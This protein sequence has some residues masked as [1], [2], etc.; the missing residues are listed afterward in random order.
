VELN[1]G[2]KKDNGQPADPPKVQDDKLTK[3]YDSQ[4]IQLN[5]QIA[6]FGQVSK[7]AEMRW[8][9]EQGALS[10]LL[11]QQKQYL[12]Q[13]TEELDDKVKQKNR[14]D[15]VAALQDEAATYGLASEQVALYRLQKLGLNQA[16]RQAAEAAIEQIQWKRDA[17]EA[18]KDLADETAR[19]ILQRNKNKQ[20][21]E[22]YIASLK[23]E[24]KM[25]SMTSKE[26]A[27][28]KNVASLSADATDD[29]KAAVAALTA[30][31]EDQRKALKDTQ[32]AAKEQSKKMSEF[33]V[34]ASHNMQS[35]F[36]DFFS[37]VRT[38]NKNMLGDFVDTLLR[39]GDE[40]AASEFM[41]LL[42]G[43]FGKT[44]QLGGVAGD[45]LGWGKSLLTGYGLGG[46]SMSGSLAL[47]GAELAFANVAHEGGLVG[48]MTSGRYVDPAVF[49]DAQRYHQ[50][51]LVDGE[52]P[53]IARRGE[54]VLTASDARH[55]N[56]NSQPVINI[57]VN[58]PGADQGTIARIREMINVEMVP[59][60]INGATQ[61]TIGVLKRPGFA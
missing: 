15:E 1:N 17:T 26:M 14:A 54:E 5:K 30:Q 12:I 8:E 48:A 28:Y 47:P 29:Q 41:K 58:A 13:L 9:T 61:N 4:S 42:T 2:M 7:A 33:A 46:S 6:L 38:G 39:M 55:R 52:V 37:K 59:Q 43:D 51:G 10:K 56:N 22:E 32:D 40:L 50:G 24:A 25:L 31:I 57:T 36:S 20:S 18:E 16:E 60:I 23:E 45:L 35:A 34:Q 27:V 21:D 3:S 44:G 19:A 49:Y 53:I 11:P